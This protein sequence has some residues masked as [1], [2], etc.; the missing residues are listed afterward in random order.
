[1]PTPYLQ[2]L[3]APTQLEY[4][5]K[6]SWRTTTFP[7]WTDFFFETFRHGHRN[8]GHG[9]WWRNRQGSLYLG[10]LFLEEIH[11]WHL[12]VLPR[13][14]ETTPSYERF[15]EQ[16]PPHNQ[17][18]LWILNPQEIS[19]LDMKIQLGADQTPN[20]QL[21]WT[22]NPL[23]EPHFYTSTPTTHSNAKKAL[24][25]YKALDTTF[26]LQMTPS[27]KEIF[28]LSH[29]SHNFSPC[30]KIPFRNCNIFKSLPIPSQLRPLTHRKEG[31]SPNQYK[32]IGISLKMTHNWTGSGPNTP[33]LSTTK[34]NP[35]QGYLST[36]S[37]NKTNISMCFSQIL[38]MIATDNLDNHC[39]LST[40]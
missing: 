19:S 15:H 10:N 40:N 38:S 16:L 5:L 3:Q 32:T 26:I 2:V 17:I 14:Y 22:E 37:L 33:S 7:S 9:T 20:S 31:M 30:H 1:M 28:I 12:P 35:P 24:F 11:R 39:D 18:H 36:F 6:P 25:S 23:T 4:Y 34:E 21:P 29:N 27:Y 13:H 8:Q